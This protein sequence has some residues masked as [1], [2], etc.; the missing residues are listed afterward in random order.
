MYLGYRSVFELLK[1]IEDYLDFCSLKALI[2]TDNE[3]SDIATAANIGVN[4]KP[5]NG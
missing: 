2:T 3:L 4:N 5:V 1:M